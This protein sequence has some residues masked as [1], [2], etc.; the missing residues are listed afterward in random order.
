MSGFFA[1]FYGRFTR[2]TVVKNTEANLKFMS[3][4][5]DENIND[6]NRIIGFCQTHSSIGAF[7]TADEESL[8]ATSLRAFER[9]DEEY[10][11]SPIKEDI[12]RIIIGSDRN[13]YL[14]IVDAIDS[15]SQDVSAITR[16]LN[17]F[18]SQLNSTGFDFS[19]GFMNDPYKLKPY[20]DI[21]IIVKP[22]NYAYGERMLGFVAVALKPSF[23]T[24]AMKYYSLPKDSHLYLT[25]GEKSYE[26]ANGK[27][28]LLDNSDFLNEASDNLVAIEIKASGC[29]ISQTISTTELDSYT[30]YYYT[31]IVTVLFFCILI[32]LIITVILYNVINEPVT[33]LRKRL[34]KVSSG[35]FERDPE[36]EWN[37]ELGDI[38][39]GINDLSENINH[40]LEE[41]IRDEKDKKDLEYKMLQNQINPHFLYNTLNSIKW[42]AI[43]QGSQGISDMTTAL[44]RLLRNIS[45]GAS[46]IISI[47]EEMSLVNDYFTI[48]QYR[49]GGSIKLQ[50][51][52]LDESVYDSSIVKFTLQPI[53]ENAIFHGIEPKQSQG[54]IK[55]TLS[56]ENKDVVICVEDDGVG[57][58]S[59]VI[60]KVLS[61]SSADSSSL[62][63]EIG[64]SNIQK[65]LQYEYGEQY[66]ISIESEPGEFTRMK[67]KLPYKVNM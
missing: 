39:R 24:G 67:V 38:G 30:P 31:I 14:Q 2:Q 26:M 15:T 62:F 29:K 20:N 46:T 50:T 58:T 9:L 36:I 42:M 41:R 43:T 65:R 44:S 7:L 60:E 11:S 5:I 56:R 12:Q 17:F 66:G 27:L 45:K 54:N 8:T 19:S 64:I 6:L 48:Q 25:L 51:E 34:E 53:V 57:M 18:E 47:R 3:D 33:K 13:K 1:F 37:H 61:G 21:L 22:I 4:S 32:G 10:K 59:E 35:E 63:R 23:F 40:L 52:C 28:T 49:Y 16:G 55:I